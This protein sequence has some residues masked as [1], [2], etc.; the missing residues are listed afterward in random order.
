MFDCFTKD[1]MTKVQLL[2]YP[3]HSKDAGHSHTLG[4][5][6]HTDW[7]AL[8]LL[9]QDNV[10]GLEV[11]C[12]DLS[13][14]EGLW[15]PAPNIEGALPL[16]QCWQHAPTMDLRPVPLGATQSREAFSAQQRALLGCSF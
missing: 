14:T 16:G 7:G 1:P 6:A 11:Y 13:E 2:R 4:C 15:L 3:P 10:G 12:E 5:G 8:S 9:A